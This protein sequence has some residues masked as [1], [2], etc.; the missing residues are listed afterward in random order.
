MAEFYTP[1]IY[2]KNYNVKAFVR[3]Y[4]RL[5]D[6]N[7]LRA[8]KQQYLKKLDR[9][10]A[11]LSDIDFNKNILFFCSKPLYREIFLSGFR[12]LDKLSTYCFYNMADLVD[13]GFG[14]RREG[15]GLPGDAQYF[16]EGDI[17]ERVMC[18]TI[19]MEKQNKYGIGITCQTIQRRIDNV[20]NSLNWVFFCG[21][22]QEFQSEYYSPLK[23]LFED[24]YRQDTFRVIDLNNRFGWVYGETSVRP[25]IGHGAE[26]AGIAPIYVPSGTG[27]QTIPLSSASPENRDLADTLG[28]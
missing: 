19:N 23:A 8:N 18:L 4:H 21:T 15:T 14:G 26:V 16:S 27:D 17:R 22:R 12:R 2:D 10:S 20:R 6:G 28:Y 24:S 5:F 9:I 1:V 3:Q 25:L 11:E 7:A 13:I